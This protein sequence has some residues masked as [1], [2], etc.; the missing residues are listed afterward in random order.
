MIDENIVKNIVYSYH[1]KLPE[2]ILDKI[3]EIVRK[4]QLSEKELIA[5]IEECIK[6][7]N[8]ALV[9]PGE[10]VGMVAAQSIGEP[11]TQMTLRTFHFAGVR[12]FNITLGLPRLIEI[13]DARKSPSTPITYI[14]L[15]KKH[16]Y[17]EEKAKEVARRIELTTIENVA[18]EW[19]LDYL[20][21][22]IIIKL[23][24]EML[25]DKGVSTKD[26]I[27]AINK[28]KGK[29]GRVYM[30]DDYTVVYE[31]EITDMSKLRRMYDRVKDLRLKGIKGIKKIILRK[32][33]EGEKTEYMLIAEGSNFAAVLSIEGVDYTRTI[34]NNIV[35]VAEVLGIEAARKVII[36]EMQEVLSEQGLDV[37]IR[38]IMLVADA[39]TYTGHVRQVGR[40]GVAGEKTSP[41]ARATFEV[42]VKHLTDAAIHGEIDRLAGVVENV[43]VGSMPVPMGTGMVELLMVF[44]VKKKG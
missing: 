37:D 40:H 25:A 11:S 23:D 6:E 9:E 22:T 13:V 26:V 38:H 35:E 14:Y 1:D 12:E 31:T 5:F 29:K 42:T 24:P 28:I 3:I 4:E 43:I 30:K 33:G 10:A 2:K 41:L 36:K 17:D 44:P 8:E 19:E 32:I 18:S 34:T 21:S 15:D 7:Y 16:R 39:M 27:K 20:T